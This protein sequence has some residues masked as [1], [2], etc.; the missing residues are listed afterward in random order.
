MVFESSIKTF[1]ASSVG[2]GARAYHSL[3]AD[4][5]YIHAPV[6]TLSTLSAQRI[7]DAN[8]EAKK[9]K[10]KIYIQLSP[11]EKNSGKDVA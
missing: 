11:N 7:T 1:G 10:K 5:E 8:Y 3:Q 2:R 6:K 9:P 4:L